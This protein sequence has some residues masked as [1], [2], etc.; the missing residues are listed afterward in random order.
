VRVSPAPG[1]PPEW[2]E[3]AETARNIA[4]ARHV[5]DAM[6]PYA[7]GASYVN[8]MSHD[9]RENPAEVAYG[10]TLARLRGLKTR[11]DPE[12]LFHLNH[13]IRPTS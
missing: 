4:W 12:N 5:Y 11:Y 7:A 10:P 9:E 3:P 6:R 1:R 2:L 13:N 8:Y